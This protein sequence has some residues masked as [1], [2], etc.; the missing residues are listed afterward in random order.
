MRDSISVDRNLLQEAIRFPIVQNFASR[1]RNFLNLDK[2]LLLALLQPLERRPPK[3]AVDARPRGGK[4]ALMYA[5]PCDS[6]ILLHIWN[7]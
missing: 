7:T 3:D 6:V 4:D 5:L 1:T 2:H